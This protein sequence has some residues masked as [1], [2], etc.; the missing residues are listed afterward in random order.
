MKRKGKNSADKTETVKKYTSN[1]M[2]MMRKGKK[3]KQNRG[4]RKGSVI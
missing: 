1:E 2:Q 4:R 3:R